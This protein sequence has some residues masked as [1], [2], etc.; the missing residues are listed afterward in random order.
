MIKYINLVGERR[1][2]TQW[3][4][5]LLLSNFKIEHGCKFGWKHWFFNEPW[6]TK[7]FES[8]NM[9][10][11]L[12]V[13]LFKNPYSWL[14]SMHIGAP[15]AFDHQGLNWNEFITKEWAS[16]EKINGITEM[17]FERNQQTGE[18]FKNIL[19]LRNA[20]NTH[21]K[22]E[23]PTKATNVHFINYEKLLENP[24]KEILNIVDNYDIPFNGFINSDYNTCFTKKDYFLNQQYFDNIPKDIINI[25]ND[26]LDWDIENEIGYI[27]H[28]Q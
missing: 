17:M 8:N 19:E 16:Y 18:R 5:S 4:N 6:Q 21:F 27:K 9:D 12:F 7:Q 28:E 15:H 10:E 24:E 13:V 25:I 2:G 22:R 20:K 23:L 14:D 1:S 26:G 11:V 3:L